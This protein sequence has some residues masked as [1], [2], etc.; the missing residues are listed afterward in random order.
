LLHKARVYTAENNSI[1]GQREFIFDSSN[2]ND[3]KI[4]I[5]FKTAFSISYSPILSLSQLA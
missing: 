3:C 5:Y 4:S 2:F 1:T